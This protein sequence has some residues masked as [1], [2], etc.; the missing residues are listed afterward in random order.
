MNSCS[1]SKIKTAKCKKKK[2]VVLGETKDDDRFSQEILDDFYLRDYERRRRPKA[3]ASPRR[4]SAPGAGT[5]PIVK[6][7]YPKSGVV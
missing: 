7:P 5:A 4:A 2:V 6:L 1:K 3:P